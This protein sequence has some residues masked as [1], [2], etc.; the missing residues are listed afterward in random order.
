MFKD[1]FA[2]ELV[3]TIDNHKDL[4][5]FAKLRSSFIKIGHGHFPFLI[6]HY[7]ELL[8][9]DLPLEGILL[10]QG[11]CTIVRCVI[12]EDYSVVVIVLLKD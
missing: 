9:R 2:N 11:P 12:D 1:L 8:L 5:G 3:I 4:E 6:N 7:F 10:D